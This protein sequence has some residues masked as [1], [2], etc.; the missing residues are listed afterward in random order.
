MLLPHFLVTYPSLVE[1]MLLIFVPKLSLVYFGNEEDLALATSTSAGKT[2]TGR[3]GGNTATNSGS[4]VSS[5]GNDT[6]R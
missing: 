3:A 5:D 6:E 2:S 1:V 4:V